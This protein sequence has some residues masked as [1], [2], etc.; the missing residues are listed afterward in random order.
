MNDKEEVLS[1]ARTFRIPFAIEISVVG[2]PSVPGLLPWRP[3][4]KVAQSIIYP[5]SVPEKRFDFYLRS[6]SAL[7]TA[8]LNGQEVICA[9][10]HFYRALARWER[11]SKP[12]KT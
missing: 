7:W 1:T 2:S 6:G 12:P 9:H 11:A 3:L 10:F 8:R 5:A 4:A